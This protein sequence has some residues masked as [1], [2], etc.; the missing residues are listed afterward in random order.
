MLNIL[1]AVLQ[2]TE[3]QIVIDGQPTTLTGLLT[4]APPGSR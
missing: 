2:A 4:P 1:S 3:G